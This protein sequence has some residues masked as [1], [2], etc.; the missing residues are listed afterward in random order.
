MS[1]NK[2][3]FE[4]SIAANRNLLA[5][6]MVSLTIIA[7]A[8][9]AIFYYN[10]AGKNQTEVSEKIFNALLPMFA[11]WVGTILAFYFG[12]ENFEAA[13]QRYDQIITKMTPELLDDVFAEQIMIDKKT[14][15]SISISEANKKSVKQLLE[16]MDNV[17]KSRLPILNNDKVVGIVHKS[18]FLAAIQKDPSVEINFPDF[19]IDYK[20]TINTFLEVEKSIKLENIREKL[21]ANSNVKDVF[22]V[23]E[24]KNILGWLTDT[25]ILQYIRK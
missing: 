9:I 6:I 25:L 21:K 10:S 19:L 2:S 23:D 20:N 17:S 18:T 22:V 8:I 1:Q 3:I 11:T 15:V 14:M 12:R 7:I 13:T 16:F 5:L 4:K 24:N